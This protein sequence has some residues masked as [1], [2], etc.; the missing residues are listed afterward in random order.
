MDK[1]KIIIRGAREHN[2]K[3]IN[4]D[5]PRDKFIVF[6]GLSGSGK[7]TL[8]YD[9]IF[10]EGQRRY[11]ESLSSY[12]RQFLGQMDKPDIDYIEGLSP[13]IS[14]DQKAASHNPRSTVGT[15]TEIHDYLRL[16]YAK[17]GIPHCPVCGKEIAKLS[18]DEIVEKI[19]GITPVHSGSAATAI[20]ITSP[21]IREKKGEYSTL[22]LDL[23]RR[24]FAEAIIN[25]KKYEL[26]P[27]TKI[28][29]AR[30]KKH[31]IDVLVDKVAITDENISRIFESVEK[32]LK[33]SGG[34][35]K[36]KFSIPNSQFTKK[37]QI[38]NTQNAKYQ[39]LT[40]NQNLAC[41][42][43]GVAFPEMEPRLFSFNSPFG[44]CPACEGLG[45]KK[46][47][48]PQLVVPDKNRTI[49]QGGILPW[50]FKKSSYYGGILKAV[51]DYYKISDF[52]RLRD[53][54]P[55]K[56]RSLLYGEK[57]PDIIP[58]RIHSRGGS[59]W[60]FDITWKGIIGFLEDRYFKTESDA[61][62]G[63]IEKYMSQN[64]CSVCG[65][66]RYRQESLLVTI[67]EKNIHEISTVSVSETLKFFRQIELTAREK[68]IAGKI[69]KEI[70]NRLSFLEDVG[71]GYLTLARSAN[72]LAGGETQRIRLASQIGSQLVGV[73]YIL[74][75]PSIG[76]HARDNARLLETLLKLRDIGNTLIVIEHDEETMR[77]ADYLVDIG[78]G[79][80]KLGGKIVAEG[81][82]GEVIQNKDS[83]TAKYLRGDLKIEIPPNRRP[84]KNKKSILVRGA[85]EHNL[86]NI[87]VEFPLKVLTCV[88]GVSGSGKSTLVE[89]VLYKSLS[90]KIMH[91]LERPGRHREILGD[92]YVDKVIMIDQSPIGRTP[93]SNPA[94]YTGLFT[95]IRALF[96]A[97]KDAKVRGYLPGRFSFN[98]P[99]GRCDNCAGE[100]F[101]KIEMQFM[102]DVY[103]PCDV[104]RGKRYNRETLEVKYKGKNIAEVLE[105]TVEEAADFFQNFPAIADP[106]KVLED[107]GLGYIQLGQSAT[108]LSGGEAQRIK[109]ATELARRS[110]GNT[111]YILDEPTTGLHFDDIK[112]LLGVL[113]RLVDAGNSVVVIEH[114]LDV[115]K[116]ADWVIDLGPEGGEGGGRVVAAGPPEEIAKYHKESYTAKFL[117][118][119]LKK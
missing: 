19:L 35:V 68:M 97:T 81:A 17:I 29:L 43:H 18:I 10:A 113:N 51:M 75:E 27:K 48:D 39:E 63:E 6:T 9:T 84:V 78:P 106:L 5:L 8:A 41:P 28:P 74:D 105:M 37:S 83:L 71:L 38:S 44:A 116:T 31:N 119:A 80:G 76:L 85:A 70:Q 69:L 87:S 104:C 111:L 47:I 52:V 103:L 94:T 110:T 90:N 54:P 25:G 40:F 64:P 114:N 102:P 26:T 50:S 107:V 22:L 14:I 61:V 49:A 100:G 12:A 59:V 67:K 57:V 60:K 36:V 95:P 1:N 89:D 23:F 109:L 112:K 2:L 20:E 16:L 15:V 34:I 45:V 117:K 88:T 72:T 92:H 86:K 24:G 118:E 11:L 3:N 42:D 4:L 55:E 91:S 30:Y 101:L 21:V 7:S 53:I 79:A 62:R 115:I 66:T 58:V 33:L 73:L 46:E 96:A 56:M 98:I 32:A 77:A 82:P 13:A 65:G 99:G 93:R 108:T